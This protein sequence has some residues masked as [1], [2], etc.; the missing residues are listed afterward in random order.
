MANYVSPG[1]YTREIDLTTTIPAVSSNISVIVVREPWKG[2]EYEQHYVASADQLINLLGKPTSTSAIDILSALEFLKY[3]NQLYVSN[4]RPEDATFSMVKIPTGYVEEFDELTESYTYNKVGTV[5]VVDPDTLDEYTLYN[6]KSL[7]TTD[8]SM[9]PSAIEFEISQTD[10]VMWFISNWRGTSANRIRTLVYD[11]DLFNAIRYY[12]TDL[13]DFDT[14]DGISI[15]PELSGVGE[16]IETNPSEFY[17][18]RNSDMVIDDAQQVGV[19]IQSMEQGSSTWVTQ[20]S[21]IT[22]LNQ[23]AVD[24]S[25]Q[26]LFIE[27][28][29]NEK[30][31]YV[32]VALN[33]AYKVTDSEDEIPPFGTLLFAQLTGGYNGEWGRADDVDFQAAIDSAVIGSYN[34]Y[35]NAEEIDVNLFIEADKGETVKQRLIEICQVERKDCMAILDV[36]RNLV[37]MNKGNEALDLVKWRKGQ[38]GS[39]FNPN[40]SYAACYANWLEVFDQWNKEYRWIPASGAVAGIFANTDSV[41]DPWFAAAG[42]NRAILTG[43]RRL[44]WN[45]LQGERD[46]I[47]KNGLN[48]IVSFAGQGKIVY[49]QKTLLDK[50]SAFNRINVRRLFLVLQKAISKASAYYL[51]EQNDEIT[52]LLMTNMITPFLRDVKGRRGITDFLVKIDETTNTPVRVDRNELWGDIYI[53]PTRSAEFIQLSFIATPTGAD[54][55]IFGA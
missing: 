19:I 42:L 6:Y 10:D 4:V 16:M 47:Y 26:S 54:F 17:A 50:S 8:L 9:F 28:V 55:T 23:T 5:A 13:A 51:F 24:D 12:D 29:I 18:I 7:G 30:S 39:T 53:A 27:N 46:L 37:L 32:K 35:A 36:P 25:G 15:S 44:A 41:S 52:W 43:V 14:P 1:V 31:A 40:T 34:L 33:P 20:E 48:P 2:S 21:Y 45:P 49:G 3:G 38:A 22:S 11:R